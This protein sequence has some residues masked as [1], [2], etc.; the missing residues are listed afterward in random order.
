MTT[1]KDLYTYLDA[2]YPA[3]LSCAWDNDGLML[4]GDREKEVKRV[5]CTLDVTEK[6]IAEAIDLGCDC[7]VSHHP[8]IFRKMASVN[9]GDVS[10]RRVITLLS[11]GITVMSFHTRLDAV[12]GGVNDV[13]CQTLGLTV[14]GKFGCD[15]EEIGR[16]TV[17]ETETTL[18][19]LCTRIKS[20][21]GTPC[22]HAVSAK[23]PV[24]CIAVLGG[25]GKDDW[26]AALAAGADTYI[27]GTMSYN[28]LLDA[29]AAGLNVIAA[30]H[31]YTERPVMDVVAKTITDAFSDV[32]AV[33][34][35]CPCE[36]LTL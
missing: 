2:A 30:G 15:G 29:K 25:D 5:L 33:V 21:L 27:T 36:V 17:C 32:E 9:D 12:D 10:G 34:S 18:P 3:S 4:C 7:I 31:F 16:M 24:S 14:T 1:I 19:A 20:A 6:T 23:R 28:T 8:M 35:E 11:N 26:E 13:L 22:V